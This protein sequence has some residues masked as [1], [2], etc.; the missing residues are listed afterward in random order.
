MYIFIRLCS[1]RPPLEQKDSNITIINISSVVIEL[2]QSEKPDSH[3][4]HRHAPPLS[5]LYFFLLFIMAVGNG[6][7]GLN[8][9]T[10]GAVGCL[11]SFFILA[12]LLALCVK[13][14]RTTAPDPESLLTVQRKVCGVGY[15]TFGFVLRCVSMNVCVHPFI[16]L[17]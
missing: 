16:L 6:I 9:P 12:L 8:T 4:R 7:L 3:T 13:R 15:P 2:P 1:L 11:I 5:F 10:A 14:K 17:S